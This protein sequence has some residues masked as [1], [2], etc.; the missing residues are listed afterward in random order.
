MST[1][2]YSACKGPFV[3]GLTGTTK[4]VKVQDNLSYQV[5]YTSYTRLRS[6]ITNGIITPNGVVTLTP[7]NETYTFSTYSSVNSKQ[8]IERKVTFIGVGTSAN[9]LVSLFPI[10]TY[11]DACANTLVYYPPGPTVSVTI[12]S[13]TA[14]LM[15]Q[16][17]YS[18]GSY[19]IVPFTAKTFSI[20]P[21]TTVYVVNAT[22]NVNRW[23]LRFPDT[24][25]YNLTDF[26]DC[27][28]PVTTIATIAT[29]TN[30]FIPTTLASTT[31]TKYSNITIPKFEKSTT[32]SANAASRWTTAL[33]G[34]LSTTTVFAGSNQGTN[35]ILPAGFIPSADAS[36][37]DIATS[38]LAYTI[39]GVF[40]LLFIGLFVC[41][42]KINHVPVTKLDRSEFQ[43]APAPLVPRPT[44][45]QREEANI[46]PE[47]KSKTI[48]RQQS[49]PFEAAQNDYSSTLGGKGNKSTV[50]SPF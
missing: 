45:L 8:L 16:A 11:I 17:Q 23:V 33:L 24:G 34:S 10:C 31:T 20:S 43:T 30:S 49:S 44:T 27:V 9:Q 48:N 5:N 18:Q 25:F 21:L 35:N 36:L 41:Y 14:G 37:V 42:K 46:E 40:A 1:I 7:L 26:P 19:A 2:Y 22:T 39:Y 4:T 28:V 50:Y 29:T 15:F 32:Y 13:S 38:G 47:R 12:V 6:N 3:G